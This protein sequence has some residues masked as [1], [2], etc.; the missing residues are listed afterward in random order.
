MLSPPRTPV[1]LLASKSSPIVNRPTTV[2]IPY[3]LNEKDGE[4]SIIVYKLGGGTFKVSLLFV[5]EG[6]DVGN[7]DIGYLFKVYEKKTGATSVLENLT[8]AKRALSGQLSTRIEIE[9]FEGY[10][11]WSET[12]TTGSRSL[13][14][15]MDLFR[16]TIKPHRFLRMQV[17]RRNSASLLGSR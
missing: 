7:R 3:G 2:V 17:S 5:N 10:N 12:L 11:D 4:S 9:S 1:Q 14:W 13:T 15:N 6:E 8:K 16:K